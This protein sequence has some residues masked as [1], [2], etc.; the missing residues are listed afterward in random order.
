MKKTVTQGSTTNT[1]EYLGAF[2]YLNG[3][4]QFIQHAEGYRTG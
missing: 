2:Q 1:T 3:T 4:L